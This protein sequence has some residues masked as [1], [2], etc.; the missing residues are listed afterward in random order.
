VRARAA[1]APAE[2]ADLYGRAQKRLVELVPTVPLF[3]NHTIV[4]HHRRVRGLFFDTSHNVP[5]FTSVWLDPAA[6]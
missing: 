1:T 3:E 4:A 6:R 2:L 5:I